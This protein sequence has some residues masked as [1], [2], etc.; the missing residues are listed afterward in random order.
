MSHRVSLVCVGILA[1]L[2]ALGLTASPLPAATITVNSTAD[3][4]NPEDRRCTLREAIIAAN[5]NVA[6]GPGAGECVK[7]DPGSDAIVFVDLPGSPDVYAL[8]IPPSA[9]NDAHSGDLNITEDLIITGGAISFFLWE[10]TIDGGRLDRVFHIGPGIFVQIERVAIQNGAVIDHGA[11]VANE[12]GA[13][14]VRRSLIVGNGATCDFPGCFVSGAGLWN[15]GTLVI[16]DTLIADNV[17]RCTTATCDAFGGGIYNDGGGILVLD[18]SVIFSNDAR[19]TGEGCSAHGGGIWNGNEAALVNGGA[20]RNS[21]ECDAE[22]SLVCSAHGGGVFNSQGTVFVSASI[23]DNRAECRSSFLEQTA[24][25]ARGGGLSNHLGV[26]TISGTSVVENSARS[27]CVLPPCGTG[28]GGRPHGGGIHNEGHLHLAGSR[29]SSNLAGCG[30]GECL[31]RGG[32]LFSDPFFESHAVVV[33]DSTFSGNN[34]VS[35][36][37]ALGAGIHN[38]GRLEVERSTFALNFAFGYREVRG[39]GIVSAGDARIVN[40]TVSGNFAACWK[41][42]CL[43]VGGGGFY[44]PGSTIS[45]F[46]STDFAFATD[47]AFT[48]FVGNFVF[49]PSCNAL[50]GG[51]FAHGDMTLRI[52]EVIV[53]DSAPND[54]DQFATTP[55]SVTA[56]GVNLD[57]DGSCPGFSLPGTNPLLGPLASN[58]GPTATH[59]PLAGSPAIDAASDCL[60][61]QGNPVLVDQ[62]NTARP[63]GPGCDLGA[64]ER[65]LAFGPAP[66]PG[67]PRE[68]SATNDRTMCRMLRTFDRGLRRHERSGVLDPEDADAIREIAERL[69]AGVECPGPRHPRLDEPEDRE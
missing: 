23:R 16:E 49:C 3:V 40:T 5:T 11:G 27:L 45:G 60:A 1:F 33:S 43:G 21:V 39:G 19:C 26:M 53:A 9:T 65:F 24:C 55:Q 18:N 12:T 52:K 35:P 17:A 62:R 36:F 30:K 31:A 15:R 59:V 66:I 57:T 6:S 28:G 41:Q 58:G 54:C 25:T 8:A 38:V 32:G 34:V 64:V 68:R 56:L 61:I 46:G 47:V 48:T 10:T 4:I 63:K 20:L 13:L 7:G 37:S 50:G 67:L 22:Q 51:V 29:V 44:L 14:V 42:G 69:R 2:S